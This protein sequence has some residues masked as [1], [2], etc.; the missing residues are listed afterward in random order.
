MQRMLWKIFPIVRWTFFDTKTNI[1]DAE[2]KSLILGKLFPMLINVFDIAIDVF[3][4]KVNV[5]N[6]KMNV[7]DAWWDKCFP[8]CD[9]H[10]FP[11]LWFTYVSNAKMKIFWCQDKSFHCMVR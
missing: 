10:M 6:A 3:D 1:S 9:L 7:Y 11:M 5:S 2:I 4:A 8:C